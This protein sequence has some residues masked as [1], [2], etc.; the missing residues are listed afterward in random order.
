MMIATILEAIG[1]ACALV[2]ALLL[3]NV[4]IGALSIGGDLL[5]VLFSALWR[6][7]LAR[8][9]VE[10]SSLTSEKRIASL[11]GLG[12]VF[13]GFLLQLAGY[14]LQLALTSR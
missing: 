4:Y 14:I 9:A 6:G 11:Q 3:A 1:A 7:S 5:S 13:L 10:V 8:G 12:F 2:G